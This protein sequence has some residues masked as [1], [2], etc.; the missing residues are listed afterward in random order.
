MGQAL[1]SDMVK[2]IVEEEL[3]K[4]VESYN[5]DVQSID[6]DVESKTVDVTFGFKTAGDGYIGI[7]LD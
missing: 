2:K 6:I 5:L 1:N 7:L 4:I 3:E